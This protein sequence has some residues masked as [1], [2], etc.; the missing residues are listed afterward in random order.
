MKKLILICGPLSSRSG[1]GN[2]TRDIFKALYS[3]SKYEI[4]VM[5]VPWGAC[6]RNALKNDSE[7]AK[8]MSES[9]IFPGPK[10][11]ELPK[12]PDVYIDVRIPN[13]FQQIGK[14]N[15]GI[16]AGVETNIVSPAFIQGCN[17]MDCTIVTSEHSKEG[18]TNAVYDKLQQ[19]PN[20]QQQK[21]GSIKLEKAMEVLFEGLEKHKFYSKKT[22]DIKTNIKSTL[23]DIKENFCFLM[24]GQWCKG[25]FGEDRKDIA[26]GIKIFLETFANRTTLPALVIKT[27]GASQSILDR[28]DCIKKIKQIKDLFPKDVTLPNVYLLHGNLN[29]EEINDLYNHSKI[30]CFYMITHGEG[31]GR[32][33]LEASFTGLPIITSNWSGHLDFLNSEKSLLVGGEL[34]KVPKSVVWK[35]IVES[36]SQWFVAD[37]KQTSDCLQHAYTNYNQVKK[38]ANELMIENREKF[39][40]EQMAKKLDDIIEKYLKGAPE[41]VQLK[42]PKL[43]K[44]GKQDTEAPK[45]KIK[46]PKLNKVPA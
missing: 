26:R 32:P 35:D 18:F 40:S 14:I 12:Q 20:G 8:V 31:F 4:K 11:I 44:V 2:H 21:V 17:K 24:V 39:N 16:T 27:S 25:G 28:E 46:L 1:Y 36:E 45:T 23:D 22:S 5:D 10:G 19:L 29:T 6:P 3:L 7:L 15:I 30:K 41:Q 38:H 9:I 34:Q 33:F 37:E 13:E 43:K 42:L